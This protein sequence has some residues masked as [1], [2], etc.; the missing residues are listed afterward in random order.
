MTLRSPT[1]LFGTFEEKGYCFEALMPA[2]DE[3]RCEFRLQVKANGGLLL[4]IPV[5]MLYRPIFGPDVGDVAALEDLTDRVVTALPPC[6][7]LDERR[8]AELKTEFETQTA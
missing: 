1:D 5:A 8:L 6:E 3:E 4:D 7:A 2:S